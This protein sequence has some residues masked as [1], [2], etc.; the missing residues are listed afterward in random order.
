LS[1]KQVKTDYCSIEVL[2]P[3]DRDSSFEPVLLPKRQTSLGD[4]LEHKI[5]NLYVP[6]MSYFD[7]CNHLEEMYQ[8]RLS[9]ATITKITDRVIPEIEQWQ[10]M[11]LERV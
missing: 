11:S 9:P 8:L 6:Q 10:A 1:K 5:I 4:G 3:R 7:I 2:T